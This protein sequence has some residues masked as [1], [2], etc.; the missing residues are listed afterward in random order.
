MPRYIRQRDS[1]RCGPYAILNLLKWLGRDTFCKQKVNQ[2]LARGVISKILKTTT[3]GP[4][5][6]TLMGWMDVVIRGYIGGIEAKFSKRLGIRQVKKHLQQG[7]MVICSYWL[8]GIYDSHLACF[9]GYNDESDKFAITNYCRDEAMTIVDY[10]EALIL[11]FC[12]GA[13]PSGWLISKK[14]G[15]RCRSKK[16]S[17]G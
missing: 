13:K 6:G 16:C 10:D 1:F 11:M 15:M 8:A 17:K 5:K 14:E 4:D 2:S 7:G 3:T 12:K 9:V